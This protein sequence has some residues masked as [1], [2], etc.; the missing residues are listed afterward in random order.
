MALMGTAMLVTWTEVP[1]RIERDYNEWYNREHLDE[2]VALPG[3][4]RARRYVSAAGQRRPKYFATYEALSIAAL[5]S[6]EY[7]ARLANQTPW[8]QRIMARFTRFHRLTPRITVDR[9]SDGFG[10]A[11]AVMRFFPKPGR[12]SALRAWI[13]EDVLPAAAKAPCM[14]GGFL[15]EN[16][17]EAANAPAKA[18]G[19]SFPQAAEA[20]WLLLFEGADLDAVKSAQ[21]RFA[22]VT[23]LVRHGARAP[24]FAACYRLLFGAARR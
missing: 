19:V 8:S 9:T 6:P 5:T 16:D 20:E 13:G 18:R 2:R 14:L 3:F 24:V 7:L 1:A 17:L 15:G 12:E 22:A 10:G 4:T 21:A 11:V 23:K